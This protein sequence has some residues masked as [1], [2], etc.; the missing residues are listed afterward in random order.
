MSGAEDALKKLAEALG[1]LFREK[2][3]LGLQVKFEF[4]GTSEEKS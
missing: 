3:A 2:D 4:E 1:A